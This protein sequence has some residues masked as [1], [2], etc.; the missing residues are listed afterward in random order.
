MLELIGWTATVLFASSYFFK[1]AS[2]LRIA[3]AIA[4]TLWISYG[5]AIGAAPVIVA[6]LLV[7]VMAVYSTWRQHMEKTKLA[8]AEVG[9]S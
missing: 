4:A 7:A 6:N 2:R 1:R 9:D 3:Q 5:I 8:A